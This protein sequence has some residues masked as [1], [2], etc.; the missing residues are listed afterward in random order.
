MREWWIISI[1]IFLIAVLISGP[2]VFLHIFNRNYYGHRAAE[3]YFFNPKA[4]SDI[5]YTRK[6]FI[7]EKNTLRAYNYFSKTNSNIKAVILLIVG[8]KNNHN[9]YLPEI[10][11]F[12]SRGYCVFSFDPTGTG[13]S[14]G[15]NIKKLVQISIDAGNAINAIMQDSEFKDLPLFLWGYSNGGFAALSLL[16]YGYKISAV[17][18]LSAYNTTYRMMLDYSKNI[19]GHSS[20]IIYP[21]T[22]IYTR[23]ACGKNNFSSARKGLKSANIP[24]CLAHSRDDEVIPFANFEKLKKVIKNPYSVFIEYNDRNHW[25]RFVPKVQKER[26]KAE[27]CL[28]LAT[29]E[30]KCQYLRNLAKISYNVDQELLCKTADFYDS[31]IELQ[32]GKNKKSEK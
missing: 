19:I 24:V 32:N 20:F 5:A 22:L 16:A 28:N 27:K 18:A 8:I 30:D 4:F 31:V 11:Y 14:Q 9:E 7:S 3:D 21:F 26:A 29:P 1:L 6:D 12:V 15:K 23:I 2:F 25:I 13:K 17:A 10:D